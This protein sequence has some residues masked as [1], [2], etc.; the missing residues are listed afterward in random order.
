MSGGRKPTAAPLT[1][2]V[3]IMAAF[4]AIDPGKT[5]MQAAAVEECGSFAG[6]NPAEELI[7]VHLT[8]LIPAGGV[9]D[10]AKVRALIYQAIID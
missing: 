10:Q 9:G 7:V 1:L 6:I 5:L 3:P 8:Q 4:M 2:L